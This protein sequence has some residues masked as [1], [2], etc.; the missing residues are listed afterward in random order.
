[1]LR[2]VL[3]AAWLAA[4]IGCTGE[5]TNPNATDGGVGDGRPAA[6][7]ADV[8]DSDAASP[9]GVRS[10]TPEPATGSVYHVAGDGSDGADGSAG[11]PWA[12]IAHAI[13]EVPDDSTILVEPGTYQASIRLQGHFAAGVIIRSAEPYRARLRSDSGAVLFC[14][15]CSGITVEGFDIAHGGAGAGPLVIHIQGEQ[16]RRV[17]VR[18]NV[19]HDSYDNDLLKV[20]NGAAE[21][22]VAGNVF[23]N[24]E[25]S[26]EHIDVNSVADVVIEDN[27][28]MNDFAASGRQN[29]NDT[30][31]YI[32]IKDSNGDDDGIVGARNV[33]VRRNVFLNWQGSAGTNF[34]LVGEDGADYIE[35]R[36][37]LIENNLI[38]GNSSND[39]RSAM[40]IKSGEDV[41]IRHNTVVGDLPG[42]EFALRINVE[43]PAVRNEDVSIYN[44]IWSDPTGT[45]NRFAD[46]PA[47]QLGAFSID[48]NQYWNDGSPVAH[49]EQ[50]LINRS[51]DVGGIDGDPALPVHDGL[52]TPVWQGDRFRGG[53]ATTC[54]VFQALVESYG[55]PGP[56]SPG[57]DAARPDQAPNH[58]ILGRPR[59]QA[60]DI[61]AVER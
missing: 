53:A 44:N 54:E 47:G 9:P 13:T 30:S 4:S 45:M 60:P 19:I 14:Y 49:R 31:S 3:V 58:D 40:G 12:T 23:Y 55:T 37:V 46:A 2:V 56:G 42:S 8:P 57:I 51:D 21:V 35:A 25:G 61:G 1:M 18:D 29:G 6:G 32:V 10:C 27:V 41:T 38:L 39:I 15:E 59:G 7:D 16:T 52:T 26:D 50:S 22:L 17:T 20:N 34:V 11:Q 5:I 24:Q 48:N 36:G 43:N 33:T 28:F